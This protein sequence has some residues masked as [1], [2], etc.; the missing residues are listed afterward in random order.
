VSAILSQTGAKMT[1]EY[2]VIAN[3]APLLS[4]IAVLI[5][6]Y[7]YKAKQPYIRLLGFS[8]LLTLASHFLVIFF[9]SVLKIK[10]NSLLSIADIVEFAL[11]TAIYYYATNRSNKTLFTTLGVL[12]GAFS[13]INLLFVQGGD[14]NS[15]SLVVMSIITILFSLY[16]FYWL[17]QELPTTELQRLPMFWI[18][19]A[20]LIFYSG[21]LFVFVFTDYLVNV[22][23]NNM[24]FMWTMHNILKVIEILMIVVALWIDLRNIRSHS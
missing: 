16:Y 7:Q 9:V 11:I 23:N 17:L 14:I 18:N 15:F 21:N 4:L 20:L 19:S 3:I 13:L 10:Q 2:M 6:F 22:L 1:L 5:C 8:Q 12:F 24:L